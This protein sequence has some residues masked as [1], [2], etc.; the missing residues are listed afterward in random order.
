MCAST[1]I[2][3]RQLKYPLHY[4][5]F[6]PF[7][8]CWFFFGVVCMFLKHLGDSSQVLEELA[9]NRHPFSKVRGGQVAGGKG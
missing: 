2:L 8:G 1:I 3:H 5:F 4:D 6:F 7:V 9:A